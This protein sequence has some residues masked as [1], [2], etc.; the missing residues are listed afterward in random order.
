MPTGYPAQHDGIVIDECNPSAWLPEQEFTVGKL[1]AATVA[2]PAGS[3]ADLLLRAVQARLSDAA[4]TK[5][6]LSG[7]ALFD[8]LDRR[9]GGQLAAWLGALTLHPEVTDPHPWPGGLAITDPSAAQEAAAPLDPAEWE[10]SVSAPQ[11]QATDR[12]GK[13]VT[14][15]DAVLRAVRRR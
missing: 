5:S 13:A 3:I 7:R 4:Q 1:Q 9:C 8:A 14:L 6:P 12:D 2:V 15:R 10:V 11:R